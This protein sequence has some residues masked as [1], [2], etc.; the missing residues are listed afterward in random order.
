MRYVPSRFSR[1]VIEIQVENGNHVQTAPG[2]ANASDRS[3]IIAESADHIHHSHDI[4]Y[5]HTNT[6]IVPLVTSGRPRVVRAT[7][8]ITSG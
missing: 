2:H 3:D 8:H 4:G 7:P 6:C 1:N 5:Q